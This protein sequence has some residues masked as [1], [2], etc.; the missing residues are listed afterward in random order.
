MKLVSLP[1][2][3]VQAKENSSKNNPIYVLGTYFML[4]TSHVWPF[5][6]IQDK[7]SFYNPHKEHKCDD[8]IT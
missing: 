3:L 4:D 2:S 5:D 7:S 8:V 1:Q 6:N